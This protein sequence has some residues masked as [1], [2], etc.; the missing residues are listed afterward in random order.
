MK[1]F[2]QN[3]TAIDLVAVAAVASGA[4]VK[5]GAIIAVAADGA[6]IGE[7]FA[8]YVEGCYTVPKATG[9]AWAVGDTLYWDD[10]AKN[11][12]KTTTSN[13]KAGYAIAVAASGDATGA[14]RLVP[15]I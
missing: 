8:G 7:S 12:T 2:L 6:A 9:A 4:V 15:S 14:I 13:T 11:F 3:G 10:T 5:I 1:N